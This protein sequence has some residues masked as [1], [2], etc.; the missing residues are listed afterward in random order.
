MPRHIARSFGKGNNMGSGFLSDGVLETLESRLL[1]DAVLPGFGGGAKTQFTDANDQIVTVTLSGPGTGLVHLPQFGHFDATLI[2]LHGTTSASRLTITVA[3]VGNTTIGDLTADGSLGS[4]KAAKVNLDGGLTI[5]GSI[6]TLTLGNAEG[7]HLITLHAN[8]ALPVDPKV[9]ASI[10]LANVQDMS[11][12]AGDIGIKS[13]TV[14]QW[15]DSAESPTDTIIA[16][17]LG[18]LTSKGLFQADVQVT[19]SAASKN[20]VG[21][22]TLKGDMQD[23][24][25][26]VNGTI[27]TFKVSGWADD[28]RVYSTT[29][30]TSVT[31]GGSQSTDFMAGIDESAGRKADQKQFFDNAS[32]LIKSFKVTG[33]RQ[34]KG[35]AIPRFFVDSNVSSAAI[36]T[37]SLL[38]AEFDNNSTP[39]GL[40]ALGTGATGTGIKSVKYTDS[41]RSANFTWPP[42]KNVSF[43][44]RPDLTISLVQYS[45]PTA[46]AGADQTVIQGTDVAMAGSG[47]DPDGGNLTYQWTQLSGPAVELTGDNTA[48]ASFTA[49]V[50]AGQDLV[51]QLT[52]RNAGGLTGTDTITISVVAGITGI[53]AQQLTSTGGSLAG[54]T[55]PA[56]GNGVV[57]PLNV[58]EGRQVALQGTA[59]ATL[60]VPSYQW[61]QISGLAVALNSADTAN[62]GFTAPGLP[63]GATAADATL[64]FS[65]TVSYNGVAAETQIVTV[66]VRLMGD[67]NWDDVVQGP[68]ADRNALKAATAGSNFER[69]D[70]NDD[71]AVDLNDWAISV[72][73]NGRVVLP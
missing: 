45:A 38:N 15:L 2:E 62:A 46:N 16:T 42:K 19:G 28:S 39:F 11:V 35:A 44:Q 40:Y 5:D 56:N 66:R 58:Y 36:G 52:T 49:P 12:N 53:S 22:V 3:G 25:W 37:V 21:T 8:D 17:V 68:G 64:T 48:N 43:Q 30:M 61:T 54:H 32:A 7:E 10:T 71:G 69:Y 55:D 13:L 29:G 57:S 4:I 59:N 47:T 72:D 60:G 26:D 41:V 9:Q 27:G 33:I 18:K 65:L 31:V 50:A 67:V 23:S 63:D 1:L 20:A 73:N 34:A 24:Q 70:L 14:G 51:F 6:S